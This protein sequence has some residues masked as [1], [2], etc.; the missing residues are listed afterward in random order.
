MYRIICTALCFVSMAS[1]A[2]AQDSASR[3]EGPYVGAM[4][5]FNS[6]SLG[7]T[8]AFGGKTDDKM[9]GATFGGIVGFRS[10]I[11]EGILAGIEGFVNSN[12]A[13]KTYTISGVSA[14]LDADVSY[15]LNAT[16]GFATEQALFFVMAGYGWNDISAKAA[17]GAANASASS[18]GDGIRAGIGAEVPISDTLAIRVQGDWQDFDGDSSALGGSAGVVLKF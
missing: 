15:G 9:S 5:G 18:S 13:N 3:F 14:R 10:A 8:S 4:V 11:S 12:T 2:S 7:D 6:Y 16:L 17:S 1:F